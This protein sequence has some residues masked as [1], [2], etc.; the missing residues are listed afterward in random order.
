MSIHYAF[1]RGDLPELTLTGHALQQAGF[2]AGTLFRISLYRNGLI[3]T[4]LNEDTDIAALLTELD[5]CETEGADWV[6]DNGELTL[7]G[8]WLTQ[9]GLLGQPLSIEVLPGK[10]TIRAEQG[11]MLA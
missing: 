4:R 6:G 11:S 3:L 7:A 10:I 1:Q 5:G 2:A 9:S 8:D